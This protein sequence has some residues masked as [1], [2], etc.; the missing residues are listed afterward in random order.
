M[1]MLENNQI[2]NDMN[3]KLKEN[4]YESPDLEVMELLSEGVIC[5]SG[6]QEDYIGDDDFVTGW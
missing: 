5:A 3:W 2:I 4:S 1:H 6:S